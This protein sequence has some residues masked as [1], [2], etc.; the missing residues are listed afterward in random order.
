MASFDPYLSPNSAHV[1]GRSA[2][3]SGAASGYRVFPRRVLNGDRSADMGW[4]LILYPP[5]HNSSTCASKKRTIVYE[6]A[7]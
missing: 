4:Q 7:G 5:R 1:A 3:S 6:I 2:V